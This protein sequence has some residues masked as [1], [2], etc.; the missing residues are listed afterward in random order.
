VNREP[1]AIHRYVSRQLRYAR[2]FGVSGRS[3]ALMNGISDADIERSAAAVAA[4]NREFL[5]ARLAVYE[6]IEDP[7]LLSPARSFALT[8]LLEGNHQDV[9][10]KAMDRLGRL[11]DRYALLI[12]AL[13]LARGRGVPE[14]DGLWAAIATSLLSEQQAGQGPYPSPSEERAAINRA[15]AGAIHDLLEHAAPYIVVDN[16]HEQDRN[17]VTDELS[18]PSTV[19]RLAHRTF[20]EYFQ[21]NRSVM[22]DYRAAQRS[23]AAALL[24]YAREIKAADPDA[25]LHPYL[26]RHLSGHIADADLWN[27]LVMAPRVLDGLDAEAVTADALR[28]LFGRRDIPALIAG[29]IGARDA[30]VRAAPMDRAGLRQ[31][32]SATYGGDQLIEEP[33]RSWGIA[34]GQVAQSVMHIR[35]AGHE[36]PLN[37][38]CMVSLPDGRDAVASTG[39]DGTIRLWDPQTATPIG[40]PLVGH[41]TTVEDVCA[42]HLPNNG[43]VRLASAGADGT[44]RVWDPVSGQP[45]GMI[46]RGHTGPIWVVCALPGV[47]ETG[48]PDGRVWLASAGGDGTIRV[49]DAVSGSPVGDPLT[50]HTGPVWGLCAVPRVDATGATDG[51]MWVASGGVDETVRLWD[52]ATGQ[53]VGLPLTAGTGPVRGLCAV[54]G[55]DEAGKADGRH[56]LAAAGS[57]GSLQVWDPATGRPVG[58]SLRGQVGPVR[59]VCAVPRPQEYGV[60]KGRAWLAAAG[61]DGRI[62]LWD[63]VTSQSVKNPLAGHSG[64]VFG[65]CGVIT[66]A[67]ENEDGR[68]WLASVGGDSTVRIWELTTTRP[69]GQGLTDRTGPVYEVCAVPGT[70]ASGIANGK[71]WVASASADGAIRLWDPASGYCIGDPLTGHSGAVN[72][73]CALPRLDGSGAPDGRV[74]LASAGAD[75]TVRIWDPSTGQQTGPALTGHVGAVH[76]ICAL[77]GF[78]GSGAPDGRVWLA[79]AGADSTVRIWD[80]ATGQQTGP[81]LT[82]HVGTINEVTAIPGLDEAGIADGRVWLASA[83]ADST[84]RIWDPAAGRS[85]GSP[86]TGH[87]GPVHTV[88][89]ILRVETTENWDDAVRLASAGAD[90]MVH[91]WDLAS[92]RPVGQPLTGHAGEVHRVSFIREPDRTAGS[93]DWLVTAGDDGT[94]RMWAAASGSPV[95]ES[96]GGPTAAVASLHDLGSQSQP[97]YCVARSEGQID[98]WD[99]ARGDIVP[100]PKHRR[101]SALA[102]IPAL[103]DGP[104]PLVIADT[105]G[106]V[107]LTAVDGTAHTQPVRI[108]DGAIVSVQALPGV[109][110]RIA[111]ADSTGNITIWHAS[112]P[113]GDRRSL[114]GHTDTVRELRLIPRQEEALLASASNDG[115]IRLW[116][117]ETWQPHGSPLTGHEG[118][119]WSIAVVTGKEAGTY[120]LASAGADRTIRLWDIDT[121]RIIA[122]PL[123][124]HTDQVRTV[125]AVSILDGR[126]VLA[127]GGHDGTIRLWHPSSGEPVH[128]IPLGIPVHALL[129]QRPDERSRERT[130][131]GASITVGLRTGVLTLDLNQSIFPLA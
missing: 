30:L 45:T 78:D 27:D 88:C 69:S 70:D 72:G 74:W 13:S 43:A 122:D 106:Q 71:V 128:T 131:D 129:Q 5:H 96:L 108:G 14:A 7:T 46:L 54:L 23:A 32:A 49:W 24:A 6:L 44:V 59:G 130:Q 89:A 17:A 40:G 75:G 16:Q 25:V 99:P 47:D 113:S 80:P 62:E 38:V 58:P 101:V 86:L 102:R 12:E 111:A 121:G 120:H 95:G 4:Q 66:R 105:E 81:A 103:T 110:A 77:P 60:G 63:P 10:A 2:D 56:W 104:T 42:F 94:I 123:L 28:T 53:P 29:V 20:A 31:L 1:V 15:W 119:V 79:S 52:P 22:V 68:V 118:R 84:I 100:M 65:V 64:T 112:A 55:A 21:G 76:C 19:Y 50:G 83:G 92:G 109:P 115:T 87:T 11:D 51:R 90:G 8:R 57:D 125:I 73:V 39:D 91:F 26:V 82:G 18:G 33:T 36:G 97:M 41:E 107:T 67:S 124:G 85:I 3:A 34:A 126:S 127:S 61:S 114:T 48:Q 117:L 116:H 93:E 35:L 98:R 9:F 37:K